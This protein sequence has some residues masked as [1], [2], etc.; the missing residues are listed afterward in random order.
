MPTRLRH[1]PL[2]HHQARVHRDDR[3]R[4]DDLPIPRPG[5]RRL[6]GPLPQHPS[7]MG[8]QNRVLGQRGHSDYGHRSAY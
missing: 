3:P 6:Q 8:L 7:Q 4:E 5:K 1:K 2:A